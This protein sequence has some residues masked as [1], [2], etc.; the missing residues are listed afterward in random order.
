LDRPQRELPFPAG[1]RAAPSARARRRVGDAA[2][3][4]RMFY[5]LGVDGVFSDFPAEARRRAAS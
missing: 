1:P 2:V 5:K 3:V 4:Y